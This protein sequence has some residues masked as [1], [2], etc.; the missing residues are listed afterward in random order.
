MFH[1]EYTYSWFRNPDCPTLIYFKDTV[2]VSSVPNARDKVAGETRRL[3][4]QEHLAYLASDA[5]SH[6]CGTAQS[7]MRGREATERH[8][9]SKISH[10]PAV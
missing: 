1:T 7:Q 9:T 2:L 8:R 6:R 10:G 4:C 5:C 3:P